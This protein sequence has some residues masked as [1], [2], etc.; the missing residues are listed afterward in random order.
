MAVEPGQEESR[1]EEG[2][3]IGVPAATRPPQFLDLWLN[4][5]TL[6]ATA[7]R[8]AHVSARPLNAGIR[9]MV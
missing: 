1:A 5:D 6:S 3:D 7:L 9:C 2:Q 4:K 8:C